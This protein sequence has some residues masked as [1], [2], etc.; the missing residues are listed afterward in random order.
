MK[1][2]IDDSSLVPN[3]LRFLAQ[4]SDLVV[5]RLDEHEIEANAIGSYND[6]AN[7]MELELLLRVWAAAHPDVR[8]ELVEVS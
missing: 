8:A 1:I 5:D 7:R 2:W 3:L 4:R 6:D